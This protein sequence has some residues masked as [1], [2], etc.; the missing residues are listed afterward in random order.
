MKVI[1]PIAIATFLWVGGAFSM[2]TV[3]VD[4]T[5][6]ALPP[7]DA[8]FASLKAAIIKDPAVLGSMPTLLRAAGI[9]D[10]ACPAC[11]SHDFLQ[12]YFI[13]NIV[14]ESL[15]KQVKNNPAWQQLALEWVQKKM[16][17][18]SHSDEEDEPTTEGAAPHETPYQHI[19]SACARTPALAWLPGIGECTCQTYARQ[20]CGLRAKA[21]QDIA[22]WIVKQQWPLDKKIVITDFAS[23]ELF[24]TFMVLNKLI[25][26]GYHNF[27]LNIID[28]AYTSF[29]KSATTDTLNIAALARGA[30]DH[31]ISLLTPVLR[32][33]YIKNSDATKQE[34]LTDPHVPGEVYSQLKTMHVITFLNSFIYWFTKVLNV[35][36]TLFINAP[37]RKISDIILPS[38]KK[39]VTAGVA[40]VRIGSSIKKSAY[41]NPKSSRAVDGHFVPASVQ[42]F[43]LDQKTTV[44]MGIDIADRTVEEAMRAMRCAVVDEPSIS[45]FLARKNYTHSGRAKVEVLRDHD[46]CFGA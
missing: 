21:E 23:G 17:I 39:P 18:H 12:T 27:Q 15:P 10:D 34:D 28:P 31:A 7:G 26:L 4:T 41:K 11:N 38:S 3:Q 16:N 35:N 5:G 24:S 9:S 13:G 29:V 45:V 1:S 8:A 43:Y 30:T 6:A 44:F 40:R 33:L 42:P 19:A 20:T 2:F 46:G 14:R 22:D 25:S 32:G 36:I 37:E